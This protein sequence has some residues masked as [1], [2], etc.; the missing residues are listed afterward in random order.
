MKEKNEYL[1]LRPDV[2]G[3]LVLILTADIGQDE[4]PGENM[5]VVVHHVGGRQSDEL[6]GTGGV[7]QVTVDPDQPALPAHLQ[8]ELPV[9]AGL[10]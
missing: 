6:P 5:A 8:L 1:V 2:P 10:S 9:S 7:H 4:S 3:S